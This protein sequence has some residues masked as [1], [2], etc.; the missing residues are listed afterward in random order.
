MFGPSQGQRLVGLSGAPLLGRLPIDPRIAALCDEG[1]IEEYDSAVS[2]RW[3][4]NFMT[5]LDQREGARPALP[6]ISSRS[7]A[8]KARADAGTAPRPATSAA[9]VAR[10]AP[11]QASTPVAIAT[12]PT[13]GQQRPG[14]EKSGTLN[15]LGRFLKHD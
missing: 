3:P 10:P 12:A 6:I 8:G 14:G 9:P 5:R 4:Q 11:A 1:R 7:L 15:R 13:E 2:R